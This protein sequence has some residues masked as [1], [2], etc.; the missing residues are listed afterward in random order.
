MYLLLGKM[1]GLIRIR[2]GG[3]D[4]HELEITLLIKMHLLSHKPTVH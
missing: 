3:R 2:D 1:S 4:L